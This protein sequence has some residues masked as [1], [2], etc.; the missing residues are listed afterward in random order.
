M[1]CHCDSVVVVEGINKCYSK[2]ELLM[3][4]IRYLFFI[5]EHLKYQIETGHCPGKNNIHANMLSWNNI[6]YFL[7]ITRSRPEVNSQSTS[8]ISSAG[9]YTARLDVIRLDQVVHSL[10]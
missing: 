3:H 8:A 6:I 5:S 10:Y 2:D 4:L 9:G 1:R 7:D